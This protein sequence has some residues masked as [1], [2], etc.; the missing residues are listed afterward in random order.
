[1]S[2]FINL[3]VV[4]NKTIK[5]MRVPISEETYELLKFC[6]FTWWSRSLSRDINDGNVD[7]KI[8]DNLDDIFYRVTNATIYNYL[9]IHHTEYDILDI[10]MN[11]SEI[12]MD[13]EF[14]QK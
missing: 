9:D 3:G 2:K 7:D 10:D 1:M 13:I 11:D 5:T 8:E 12:Y 6:K 4:K 14:K